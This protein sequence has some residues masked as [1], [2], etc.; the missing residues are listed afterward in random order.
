M[1]RKIGVAVLALTLSGCSANQAG[2]LNS[3]VIQTLTSDKP[4]GEVSA[5]VQQHLNGG[6]TQGTDGTKYWVT[7]Q[8]GYGMPVV[9]YDF[10]P[11]AHGSIVEYRSK[12]R[13]NNGLPKVRA[14]L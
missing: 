7:R 11:A 13:I 4:A 9:R 10:I 8:N 3:P 14:C 12:L 6:P 1:K 2:L 5:C